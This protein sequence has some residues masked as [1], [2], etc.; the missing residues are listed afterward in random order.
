MSKIE[1]NVDFSDRLIRGR[2]AEIIFE[3]MLRD[4]N[5]FT[6]LHFGYEHIVPELSRD[7][8]DRESETMKIIRRAPDFAVINKQTKKVHLIEVKFQRKLSR[9]YTLEA[10]SAMNECWNPSSLFIATLDGF[11][12]DDISNIIDNEGVIP[13]LVHKMIPI[14]LQEKYLNL[15]RKYESK[16]LE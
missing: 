11:F 7:P 2:I 6:V 14:E 16:V 4:T 12:F 1:R 3:Q 10:A 13:P 15:L 8:K 5:D 9:T